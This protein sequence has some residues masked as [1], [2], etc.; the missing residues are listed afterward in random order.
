[1]ALNQERVNKCK[2]LIDQIETALASQENTELYDNS[3]LLELQSV[4]NNLNTRIEQALNESHK[5]TIGII[6][7]VKAGKSSF[8][9][10]LLFD[11]EDILPK[12]ATP[13][14]AALTKISYAAEPSAVVHFYNKADWDKIETLD[15]EYTDGLQKEYQKYEEWY[16]EACKEIDYYNMNVRDIREPMKQKPPHLTTEEYERKKYRQ[17]AQENQT[18]AHELMQ[19]LT[20]KSVLDQLGQTVTVSST[21]DY[22]GSRG[23][24]T[25]IVKY[26][27]MQ[28]N[29]ER[30]KAFE[31]V[32]TPGLND[33]ITS[34]SNVTKRFLSQCDV[35]IL[36]SPT[37]QFMDASTMSLMYR[38]LPQSGVAELLIV[39]SKLDSGMLDYPRDGLPIKTVFLESCKKY[40]DMYKTNLAALRQSDPVAA[41]RM[42]NTPVLFCSSLLHAI[43][44]KK[45]KNEPLNPEEQKVIDNFTKRFTG[46]VP[47]QKNAAGI[48]NFIEIRNA[49][50]E[51]AKRRDEILDGRN[52]TLL[53][54]SR[55]QISYV[56]D[57]IEVDAR[58]RLADLQSKEIGKLRT[59]HEE[60]RDVFG[61]SRLK[62]R[63]VFD[64]SAAEA[65][66]TVGL[67]SAKLQKEMSNHLI[68]TTK[69][70]K[71]TIERKRKTGFLNLETEYYTEEICTNSAETVQVISNL[72]NYNARCTEIIHDDFDYL[73][74]AQA[75]SNKVKRLVI[76]IMQ[77]AGTSYTEEDVLI[78]LNTTLA[79]IK[80]PIITLSADEYVDMVNSAFKD[81]YAENERIHELNLLQSTLLSQMYEAAKKDLEK[82]AGNVND[83][84]SKQ[85]EQFTD[86]ILGKLQS[87]FD[88][89]VKQ[90]EDKQLYIARYQA[91]LKQLR[92]LR[93]LLT[94][95]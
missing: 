83:M 37:S 93:S 71:E 28:I 70:H 22:I 14:T 72:N 4:R 23:R 16:A 53:D 59:D 48:G 76:E 21:E 66:K 26:V 56:L 94:G 88:S 46:F 1:M 3:T 74:S 64:T 61:R 52:N 78:P 18:S 33:P 9:N 55:N 49:L 25:P 43:S 84:L 30:L 12:A 44:V 80:I 58:S 87:K 68:F 89:L 82:S 92:A 54:T 27:E 7:T 36:L 31:I 29:D 91:F 57:Q 20:D 45:K 67:T 32:D 35:A 81:G 90:M 10:A 38:S 79:E 51:I 77:R 6:G 62:I 19:M 15:K 50:R 95:M 17:I 63:S 69:E 60:L 13:M 8:L 65:R 47:D 85:A 86:T 24:Y 75:L 5:M 39:G 34:R 11:G 40:R 73:F 2:A 42:E 41:K